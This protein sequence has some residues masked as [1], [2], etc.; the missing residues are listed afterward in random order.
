VDAAKDIADQAL[1]AISAQSTQA[2]GALRQAIARTQ[3]NAAV[4]DFTVAEMIAV[5]RDAI[6]MY[7]N[8]NIEAR[9][10]QEPRAFAEDAFDGEEPPSSEEM[11]QTLT[12]AFSR[13]TANITA[14]KSQI[15][16]ARA[17]LESEYHSFYD[18]ELAPF[19]KNIADTAMVS[20][21]NEFVERPA[22]VA[23]R[24]SAPA[25][26]SEEPGEEAALLL[27]EE[28]HALTFRRR[29]KVR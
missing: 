8:A 20:A 26:A 3:D 2:V 13:A 28:P 27:E 24:A 14:C 29:R 12:Q 21:R 4:W 6:E 25:I 16:G 10:T 7:R 18:D 22:P 17:Q 23:A 11:L 1:A 15:A 9:T 19:L 5:G